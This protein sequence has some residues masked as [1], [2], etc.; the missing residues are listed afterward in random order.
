MSPEVKRADLIMLATERRDLDIDPNTVWPMLDGVPLADI[1]VFPLTPYQSERAFFERWDELNH[2][3][4]HHD[5]RHH[6]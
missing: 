3:E 4:S 6:D 5:Q 2:P 1:V